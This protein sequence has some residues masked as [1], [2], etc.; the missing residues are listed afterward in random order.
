MCLLQGQ[1]HNEAKEIQRHLAPGA[2]VGL[3]T[4]KK[5]LTPDSRPWLAWSLG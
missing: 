4:G 2:G 1:E 3:R 5:N